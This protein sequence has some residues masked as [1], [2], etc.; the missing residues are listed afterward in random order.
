MEEGL[1]CVLWYWPHSDIAVDGSH[2]ARMSKARCILSEEK[3][4]DGDSKK[5]AQNTE[6][7]N[8]G[9][10]SHRLPSVMTAQPPNLSESWLPLHPK[11]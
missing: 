11:G 1:R 10:S 7:Q 5:K 2:N 4:S 8:L 3:H 9:S 6:G